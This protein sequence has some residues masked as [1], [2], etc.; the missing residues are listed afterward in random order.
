MSATPLSSAR[1]EDRPD[2][3]LPAHAAITTPPGVEPMTV[4]LRPPDEPSRGSVALDVCGGAWQRQGD[5]W[6]TATSNINMFGGWSWS[7]INARFGPLRLIYDYE[8]DP[9]AVGRA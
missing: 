6:Y 3:T 1:D 9:Q 7:E 4:R 5:C 2:T 8:D